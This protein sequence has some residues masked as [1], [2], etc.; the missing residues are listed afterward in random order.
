MN[1]SDKSEQSEP[2]CDPCTP[3][4][5]SLDLFRGQTRILIEHGGSTY[6]LQI[7]RQGK[8]ILTK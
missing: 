1:L 3:A 4:Y 7:T 6:V 2:K 8:L 5:R